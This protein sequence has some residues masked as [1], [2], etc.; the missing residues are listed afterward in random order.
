MENESKIV[1]GIGKTIGEISEQIVAAGK[2]SKEVRSQTVYLGKGREVFV[3][4][5]EKDQIPEIGISPDFNSLM[6]ICEKTGIDPNSLE[7]KL[8]PLENTGVTKNVL[9]WKK[10]EIS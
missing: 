5:K 4:F 6:K 10:K 8:A 3:W 2:K 1:G 9:V 7:L